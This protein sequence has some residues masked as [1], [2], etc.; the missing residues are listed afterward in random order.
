M[1]ENSKRRFDAVLT[2]YYEWLNAHPGGHAEQFM[3]DLYRQHLSHVAPIWNWAVEYVGAVIA[4]AGTP[5]W[6]LN[7][8]PRYSNRINRPSI[9]N[10]HRRFWATILGKCIDIAVA[11]TNYDILAEQAL[12]HRP[13]RRPPAPG[14]FYGGF[15]RPQKLKGAAQPFSAWSPERVIEL[16]GRV[17]VFKLH[18][19]LN[20]SLESNRLT[21]YQDLRAAFRKG[22]NAAIVPPIPDKDLPS[23]LKPVWKEAEIALRQSRVWIICGYSVPDYDVSVQTLLRESAT[24]GGRKVLVSSP[25]AEKICR[26]LSGLL[27]KSELIGVAGLP[28]GIDE[29][30][31]AF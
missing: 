30:A 21:M 11:T 6:S 4:S 10:V 15:E 9:T 1:S 17:P 8:N 25:D 27:P 23:W 28:D 7:R 3:D 2:A 5:P 13:F 31:R 18:G 14:C 19:S 26:R 12:R 20:W 22:G 29:L 16:T 24:E